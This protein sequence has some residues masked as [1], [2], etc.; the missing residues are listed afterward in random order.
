MLLG[1]RPRHYCGG[2][3]AYL[4]PRGVQGYQEM[5]EALEIEKDTGR[6][7]WELLYPAHLLNISHKEL[8]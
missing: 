7:W 3:S 8:G 4:F 6:R 5:R 1:A 2:I